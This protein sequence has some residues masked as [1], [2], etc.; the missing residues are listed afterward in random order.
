MS[1]ERTLLQWCL[2]HSNTLKS[3]WLLM[4]TRK[5]PICVYD[6]CAELFFLRPHD[7]KV[8]HHR[9]ITH[10]QKLKGYPEEFNLRLFII[11]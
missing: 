4:M 1:S 2:T 8:L 9:Y 3:L 6:Y 7:N 11:L 5:F 10:N